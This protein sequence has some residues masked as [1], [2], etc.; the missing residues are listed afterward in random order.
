MCQYAN[1]PMSCASRIDCLLE[2]L[3]FQNSWLINVPICQ[4]ANGVVLGRLVVGQA[5]VTFR[6]LTS[7]Y[8][9]LLRC[10]MKIHSLLKLFFHPFRGVLLVEKN[11]RIMFPLDTPLGVHYENRKHPLK[12]LGLQP[13]EQFTQQV[14]WHIGILAH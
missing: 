1:V 7:F 11:D 3:L 5:L 9:T 14:N 2:Q 4:C 13:P 10:G 8:N 6:S 12:Q